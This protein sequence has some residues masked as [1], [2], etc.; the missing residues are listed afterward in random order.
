MATKKLR[1][2]VSVPLS[3]VKIEH[4]TIIKCYA[5]FVP[6]DV[7][8]AKGFHLPEWPGTILE[9]WGKGEEL[10]PDKVRGKNLLC[11]C[12][13]VCACA[14]VCVCLRV[15]VCVYMH[16]CVRACVSVHVCV[17]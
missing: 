16:A 12:V 10:P 2:L 3:Q 7:V 6:G 1:L 9:S 14:C 5:N 17:H 11:V 8:W 13:C 4:H 15:R